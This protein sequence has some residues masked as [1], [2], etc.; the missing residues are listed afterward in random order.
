MPE[1]CRR[2]SSQL[3]RD[4]APAIETKS[5]AANRQEERRHDSDVT[6]KPPAD[7]STSRG[8][9]ESEDLDHH[10]DEVRSRQRAAATY[11]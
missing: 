10:G 7:A 11:C 5:G 8:S 4:L 6:P 3:T 1:N 2:V 9:D